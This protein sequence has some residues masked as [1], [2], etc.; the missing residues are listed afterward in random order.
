MSTYQEIKGLKVKYLS[1]DTS[2]DRAKEGEVFYNSASGAISA[3]VSAAGWHSSGNLNTSRQELNGA[4]TQ[5]AGLA[6]GVYTTT[7][8]LTLKNMVVLAGQLEKICQ[9]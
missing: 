3:Y 2:G 9:Q 4:G 5:T 1:A 6:M 8:Q 7:T